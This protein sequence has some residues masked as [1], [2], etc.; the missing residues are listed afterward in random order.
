MLTGIEI[1]ALT[2][3]TVG[4]LKIFAVLI[5]RKGWYQNVVTPFY[6]NSK[7]SMG[8]IGLFSVFLFFYLL[9]YFDIVQMFAI[10]AFTASFMA[11]GIMSYSKN[12][13]PSI[14]NIINSKLGFLQYLYMVIWLVLSAWVLYSIFM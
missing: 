10:M 8:V 11:F 9:N 3:A 5:N 14:K 13:L 4:L 7:L 2:L 6:N 12:I 1:I